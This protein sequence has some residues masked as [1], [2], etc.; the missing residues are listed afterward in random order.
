M[1]SLFFISAVFASICTMVVLIIL[2][3]QQDIKEWTLA[4]FTY[5]IIHYIV[6]TL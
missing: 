5:S 3:A 6:A 2:Y 1:S 4:V